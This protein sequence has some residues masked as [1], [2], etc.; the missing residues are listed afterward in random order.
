MGVLPAFKTPPAC[1]PGGPFFILNS[2][3]YSL[4]TASKCAVARAEV[5]WDLT[6]QFEYANLYMQFATAS[7]RGR[8]ELRSGLSKLGFGD[9]PNLDSHCLSLAIFP[10][11]RAAKG[12]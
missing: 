2:R 8:R 1:F 11:G 5:F 9:A 3:Y 4:S 7:L 6:K 12:T 10:V